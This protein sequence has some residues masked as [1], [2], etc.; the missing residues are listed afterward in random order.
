MLMRALD[1]TALLDE[2]IEPFFSFL[3]E[4]FVEDGEPAGIAVF[5]R[6]EIRS[7]L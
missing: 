7:I 6:M 1:W 3:G 2:E 5:V 4:I